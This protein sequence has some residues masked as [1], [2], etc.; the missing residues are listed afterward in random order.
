MEN[1]NST[2]QSV[3][4]DTL[5]EL[6]GRA[7]QRLVF[8]APGVRMK[9]AEALVAAAKRLHGKGG[10]VCI[11]DTD[12]EVCRLGYGEIEAL[13]RLRDVPGMNGGILNAQPGVRIGLVIADEDTLF[14]APTPLL[15]EDA[16][17]T[18]PGMGPDG[19]DVSILPL[20]TLKPNGILLRNGVSSTLVAA[21]TNDSR[22]EIGLDPING[23]DVVRAEESLK[24]NP[25]KKFDLARRERVFSSKAC[26]VELEITGYQFTS[27]KIDL[28][29]EF[30]V[31]DNDTRRRLSNRFKVFDKDNLP[32]NIQFERNDGTKVELSMN[33]IESEI[34][35]VRK[36]Y[37]IRAG[38]WGT[39]ILRSRM[40][41][42]KKR[43]DEIIKMLTTYKKC[44]EEQVKL[45]AG[46]ICRKLA[47]EIAPRL[48][49]TPPDSL[50]NRLALAP[51]SAEHLIIDYITK[52]CETTIEQ[53]FA[54]FDPKMKLIEK[55]I[56][57]ETFSD[58]K[59]VEYMEGT[60][61]PGCMEVIFEEHDS[62]MERPHAP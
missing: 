27:K 62:V 15:I 28:P 21:C 16:P 58:P 4:D 8:V 12:A 24:A 17:A 31:D 44:A 47:V 36:N 10:V 3:T 7:Q 35:A 20:P 55:N 46:E 1:A 9:V 26:F 42:F 14:Y 52:C 25:P 54:E 53:A 18:V 33:F 59:F 5:A 48:R 38:Q 57:Y 19:G 6:I 49:A 29:A 45:S 22:R 23:Q 41:E 40:D 60:L 30:F 56:T 2:F 50:G 34:A 37:L 51:S 61:G 11:L 39:V 32:R 43:V 13:K